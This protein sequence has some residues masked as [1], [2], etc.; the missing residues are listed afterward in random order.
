MATAGADDLIDTNPCRVQG[1]GKGHRKHQIKVAT[2]AELQAIV[3]AIP[4]RYKAMVQIAAWC[5]LRFGELT[6]LRRGDVDL[7]VGLLRVERGVVLLGEE[8]VVGTP[9]SAAG[10]RTV[11]IPPHLLPNLKEH[12]LTHVAASQSALL[13][14]AADGFSHMAPSTLYK[15]W[16]PARKAAGRDDLRFHDL[17]HKS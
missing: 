13:F 3:D 17:R 15:V 11:A 14:P 2:L 6:E 7:K 10:K 8:H 12:L 5:G 4:A 9:K 1:A 16:Y